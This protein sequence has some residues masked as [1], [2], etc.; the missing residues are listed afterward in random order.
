MTSWYH[1]TRTLTS[2]TLRSYDTPH[3][4]FLDH[5][6]RTTQIILPFISSRLAITTQ[7]I[8]S[9]ISSRLAI[10]TQIIHPCI[11]SRS[12]ITVPVCHFIYINLNKLYF[13]F[14]TKHSRPI[15]HCT[16]AAKQAFALLD[17]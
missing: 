11:I 13:N 4:S 1:K 16:V 14:Q 5:I 7:I 8:L 9:F 2:S 6:S 15:V 10:T 12:A 17:R 3:F